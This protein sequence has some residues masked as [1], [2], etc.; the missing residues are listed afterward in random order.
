MIVYKCKCILINSVNDISSTSAFSPLPKTASSLSNDPG[1]LFVTKQN[2][3]LLYHERN[4]GT[5]CVH[6]SFSYCVYAITMLKI[7]KGNKNWSPPLTQISCLIMWHW[8]K[9]D[10]RSPFPTGKSIATSFC[11]SC[12]IWYPGVDELTLM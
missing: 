12:Y 1:S 2:K 7:H 6:A 11:D 5:C 9:M 4:W 10:I 8:C 3:K